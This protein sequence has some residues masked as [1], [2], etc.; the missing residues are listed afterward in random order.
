MRGCGTS[1]AQKWLAMMAIYGLQ[2]RYT[3]LEEDL[4]MSVYEGQLVHLLLHKRANNFA[5]IKRNLKVYLFSWLDESLADRDSR[6]SLMRS[7][8]L[9]FPFLCFDTPAS[10]FFDTTTTTQLA[11]SINSTS[12]RSDRI[13]FYSIVHHFREFVVR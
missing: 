9:F 13:C 4:I 3:T 8:H 1:G 7:S 12:K 6:Y 10:L 11:T 5:I 2:A